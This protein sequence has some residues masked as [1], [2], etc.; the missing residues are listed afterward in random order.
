[1]NDTDV[2]YILINTMSMY[3]LN[4][5]FPCYMDFKAGGAAQTIKVHKTW[6][7]SV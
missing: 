2:K 1:V 6:K 5:S 3:R 4:N 7:T